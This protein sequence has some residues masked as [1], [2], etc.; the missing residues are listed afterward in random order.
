MS[1]NPGNYHHHTTPPTY[2]S[3]PGILEFQLQVGY[4][5]L[6]RDYARVSFGLLGVVGVGRSGAGGGG[7]FG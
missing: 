1:L 4:L 2:P 7:G 5:G 3:T 6:A